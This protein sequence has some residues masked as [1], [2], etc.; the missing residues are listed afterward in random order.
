MKTRIKQSVS[1]ALL[2]GAM[3]IGGVQRADAAVTVAGVATTLTIVAGYGYVLEK[4]LKV[5]EWLGDKAY[6]AFHGG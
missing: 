6:L 1:A 3:A 4:S 5:G 2:V